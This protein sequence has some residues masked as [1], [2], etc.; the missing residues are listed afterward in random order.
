MNSAVQIT[1]YSFNES[2]TDLGNKLKE[3][4]QV[5]GNYQVPTV[6]SDYNTFL[7]QT[8]VFNDVAVVKL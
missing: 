2:D 1:A 8:N 7:K 3:N 5:V 4:Q 6:S